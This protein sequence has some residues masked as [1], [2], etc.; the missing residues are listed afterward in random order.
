MVINKKRGKEIIFMNLE[1]E[2]NKIIQGK[3]KDA[4]RELAKELSEYIKKKE[5]QTDSNVYR[6][7]DSKSE[8]QLESRKIIKQY[9]DIYEVKCGEEN[10]YKINEN[11]PEYLGKTDLKDGYYLMNNG[12]LEYKTDI[13]ESIN[14]SIKNLKIAI[15]NSEKKFLEKCRTEGETY[16]VEEIGDD[17]KYVYL[18]KESDKTDFQEYEISEELYNEL[19]MNNNPEIYLIYKDGN[20]EI[21]K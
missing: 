5:N 4:S 18:Q 21:K 12:K 11:Y 16:K 8:F 6:T 7:A 1:N 10:H 13:T 20:Y 15:T 19:I 3:A 17:E 9:G 2:F 14:N